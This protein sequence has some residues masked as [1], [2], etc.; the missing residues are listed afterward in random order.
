[1]GVLVIRRV[2][3]VLVRDDPV[4]PV[5]VVLEEQRALVSDVGA[6][7]EGKGRAP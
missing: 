6:Q 1:V 5:E 7:T 3:R 4:A 2:V